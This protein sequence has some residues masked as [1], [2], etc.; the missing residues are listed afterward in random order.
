MGPG[1]RKERKL[2]LVGKMESKLY[3]KKYEKIANLIFQKK[4][5]NSFNER[6]LNIH[7]TT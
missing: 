6:N 2:V 1:K 4:K 7:V 5:R 3:S